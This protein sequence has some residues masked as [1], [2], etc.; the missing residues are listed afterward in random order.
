MKLNISEPEIGIYEN[1]ED[2][3]YFAIKACNNSK[4]S[5]LGITP[6]HSLIEME[7]SEPKRLGRAVHCYVLEGSVRFKERYKVTRKLGRGTKAWKAIVKENEK[8]STIKE[9]MQA[10]D[11]KRVYGVYKAIQEHP[12]AKEL[13]SGGMKEVVA[14][15]RDQQTGILCKAKIDHVSDPTLGY[16]C[17]LKTTKS[18]NPKEFARAI[19]NLGYHRQAYY[20]LTGLNESQ[21]YLY[22]GFKFISCET[23]P[24]FRVQIFRLD[25]EFM[26]LAKIEIEDLLRIEESCIT[27]DFYPH[28]TMDYHTGD[29]EEELQCPQW[30]AVRR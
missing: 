20:Y 6:A 2:E 8:Q 14:I 29:Y 5:L 17:D 21:P 16:I 18:A 15:W 30:A 7:D 11:F 24:P 3:D 28:Y 13:L 10:H 19:I 1:V 12:R 23:K 22:S 27:S 9:L 26:E 25:A 4:L